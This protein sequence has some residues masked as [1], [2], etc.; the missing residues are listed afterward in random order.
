M[1]LFR[2]I[3]EMIL[4]GVTKGSAK[5]RIMVDAMPAWFKFVFCLYLFR[6]TLFCFM[7]DLSSVLER[8]SE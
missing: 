5:E 2:V 4:F 1:L 6:Y 8:K 7:S 3:E